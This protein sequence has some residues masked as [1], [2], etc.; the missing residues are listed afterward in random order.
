VRAATP[1]A[2]SIDRRYALVF[3]ITFEPLAVTPGSARKTTSGCA[4]LPSSPGTGQYVVRENSTGQS[5]STEMNHQFLVG[6]EHELR[7]LVTRRRHPDIAA[8]ACRGVDANTYH[9]DHGSPDSAA[10]SRCTRCGVRVACVAVALRGEDPTARAGWFGGLGPGDRHALAAKLDLLEP[11]PDSA[12]RP[13]EAVRLRSNG[14][15]INDI[16]AHLRCSRR[17]V[18]R[19]LKLAA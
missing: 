10:L 16:A 19:Y 11:S 13:S 9:P 3:S 12:D 6:R 18:Q 7:D 8:A 4:G 5:W 1:T 17:T 2:N 14:W 15:K